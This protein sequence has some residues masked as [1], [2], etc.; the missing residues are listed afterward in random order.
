MKN[1]KNQMENIVESITNRLDQVE[2]R[3]SGTEDKFKERLH[4]YSNKNKNNKTWPQLSQ[5]LSHD[6]EIKPKNPQGKR[7][8]WDTK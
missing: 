4:S 7:R 8:S 6:Q 5:T 3:I 1:W 2:E